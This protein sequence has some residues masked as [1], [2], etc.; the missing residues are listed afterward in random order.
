MRKYNLI[1]TLIIFL[2]LIMELIC[3][4]G[5]KDDPVIPTLT[6]NTVTEVTANTAKS[7]GTIISDGGAEIL[8]MGVCWA[9][10]PNPTINDFF[11]SD[12]TVSGN[13]GFLSNIT[14]LQP[15]TTYYMRA[16][17]TNIIGTSYGEEQTFTTVTLKPVVTTST[18]SQITLVS[19]QSGGS[20]T[21][22]G[23]APVTS[24]GICWSESVNPAIQE[25]PHT[26]NGDGLGSFT[27][28]MTELNPGTKYYVRAYAVNSA[29]ISYADNELEFSTDQVVLPEVTSAPVSSV[30]VTTAVSGG[31]VTSD[32][33]GEILARGVCWN[34][35]GTPSITDQKTT[36]A[37]GTGSFISN[38][39][40][41]DAGTIYY[42]RAYVTNDAGTDYG[43]EYRFS[44]SVT[45]I[46]G[47]IYNTVIIGTQIWMG[48]DLKTTKFTDNDDIPNITVDTLWAK[49][50]TPAYS[51]YDN[52]PSYGETFGIIYNWYAV[53]TG[54]LC[55]DG[56]HVPSD[57]EFKTL[58]MYLGMSRAEADDS[59]WRGTD[60]GT[61]LKY[62][63]SWSSG[64]NGTNSSGFA[65]LGGG[66]RFGING[67]FYDMGKVAYWWTSSE[68]WSDTT[69]G[70]YRR[71]DNNQT[72]VYREGVIK[73]GGKFV[74]CLKDEM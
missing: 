31:N 9:T 8:K 54:M 68:H 60:E 11:T 67:E 36:D 57:E 14:G 12:G 59:D 19:A 45:D 3:V 23:G 63:S 10:A 32:G 41:L 38:I 35:S 73:A 40:D 64:G 56:W 25:D 43:D 39:T 24:R 58:E 71:L 30:G 27:S 65:A 1:Y 50:T 5:C 66:Y 55:P 52:N 37:P 21:Y 2:V 53:G 22:D 13:G 46:E 69:K 44:T 15:G 72:S 48:K 6:T 4:T 49:S 18:V 28:T 70:L 33:G 29:G 7:G 61:K 17:A 62:T 16:Y 34:T 51:W 26:E 47:N 20:V 42:V 74:R